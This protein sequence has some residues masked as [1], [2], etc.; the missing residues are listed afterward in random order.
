MN[1]QWFSFVQLAAALGV[2]GI[3]IAPAVSY[4]EEPT[5]DQQMVMIRSLTETERQATIAANV[6]LTEPEAAKFWP[7]YRDYRN[8]VAK[9]N[10]K[11]IALIKDYAANFEAV[12]DAKA[13]SY[14]KDYL[15]TQKQRIALKSKYASKYD[16]VLPP[17]KTA[18]V[19]QI[20]S[21]LDAIIDVALAQTIPLV[22]P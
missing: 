13:K 6:V 12:T 22:Q 8:E 3:C 7:L 1:R 5:L 18:R 21:K 20:E 11:L 15:D 4:A 14:V 2:A 10:D 19:L 16:K 9:V 17:V